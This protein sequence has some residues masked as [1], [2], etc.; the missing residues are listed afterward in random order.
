MGQQCYL[1]LRVCREIFS[2]ATLFFSSQF[3]RA[4]ISVFDTVLT[5]FLQVRESFWVKILI[6]WC[7]TPQTLTTAALCKVMVLLYYA[8]NLLICHLSIT[9]SSNMASF[10]LDFLLMK[11]DFMWPWFSFQFFFCLLKTKWCPSLPGNRRMF[12]EKDLANTEGQIYICK[13]AGH[14]CAAPFNGFELQIAAIGCN[15]TLPLINYS[16]SF[17]FWILVP[18]YKNLKWKTDGIIRCTK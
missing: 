7:N 16:G 3:V 18:I 1:V 17:K 9:V 10:S 2:N 4:H 13:C 5:A 11:T 14:I 6:L 12:P 8:A 15:S